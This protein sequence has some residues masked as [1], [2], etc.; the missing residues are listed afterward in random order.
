MDLDTVNLDTVD[1]DIVD[2]DNVDLD[3]VDLDIVDL[4][5]VDLDTVD[6][7]TVDLDT[8]DLDNVDLD[9]VNLETVDLD[10]VDLNNVDLDTVDL[11]KVDLDM[12]FQSHRTFTFRDIER[13]PIKNSSN[14]VSVGHL[15]KQRSRGSEKSKHP[16]C[17]DNCEHFAPPVELLSLKGSRD[18]SKSK[19]QSLEKLKN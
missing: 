3:T 2:L 6:L 8:V 9:T 1:L 18:I 10:T 15:E 13:K 14:L 17:F 5:T 7:D 19:K 4:D 16:P 11:D 12:I